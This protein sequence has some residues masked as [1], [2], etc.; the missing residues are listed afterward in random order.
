MC[1]IR[2]GIVLLLVA[3]IAAT[4]PLVAATA[5]ESKSSDAA[6]SADVADQKTYL[7]RYSFSPGDVVRAKVVHQATVRTTIDGTSSTADTFA[8]VN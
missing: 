8:L 3:A 1:A 6:P 5:E 7:L 4:S 2:T